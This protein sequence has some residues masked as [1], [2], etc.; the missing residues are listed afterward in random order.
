MIA[1]ATFPSL[2]R[3]NLERSGD[4]ENARKYLKLHSCRDQLLHDGYKESA[5]AMS[6]LPLLGQSLPGLEVT[7]RRKARARENKAHGPFLRRHGITAPEPLTRT[8]LCTSRGGPHGE[9]ARA[10]ER[11]IA[12]GDEARQVSQSEKANWTSTANVRLSAR[13]RREPLQ[14]RPRC[15]LRVFVLRTVHFI[16]VCAAA[17]A[18]AMSDFA[19]PLLSATLPATGQEPRP[20]GRELDALEKARPAEPASQR[21]PLRIA[22]VTEN[23]LPKIDGVTR[24]LAM[25]LE[26][27]QAEGHEAMVLGP[28]TPLVRTDSGQNSL[29]PKTDTSFHPENVCGSGSRRDKGHSAVRRLPRTRVELPAATVYP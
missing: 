17:V 24:T 22:I 15:R 9:E 4:V 16:K 12:V 19:S 3:H 14:T 10:R 13:L 5:P 7:G 26:H 25:L 28:A 21:R 6:S 20:S 8:G 27:L 18:A 11:R 29:P 2:S 1:A 23:F